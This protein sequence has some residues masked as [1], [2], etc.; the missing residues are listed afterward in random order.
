M[1]PG[2][3]SK[4]WW[5]SVRSLVF[6]RSSEPLDISDETGHPHFLG[7]RRKVPS[8]FP[9]YR[10]V[11]GPIQSLVPESGWPHPI[12]GTGEWVA[13]SNALSVIS[14]MEVIQGYHRVGGARRIQAFRNAIAAKDV[15]LFD[16]ATAD[17]DNWGHP[18]IEPRAAFLGRRWTQI[19]SRDNNT[20]L[21]NRTQEMEARSCV[22]LPGRLGDARI[23]SPRICASGS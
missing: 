6:T 4:P 1:A 2:F 13:P 14:V 9:W 7:N 10:R 18:L 23:D 11:G 15:L 22:A 21:M 12:L 5:R 8:T 20:S 19:A 3:T 17:W 16:Q